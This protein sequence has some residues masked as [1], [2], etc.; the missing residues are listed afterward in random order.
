MAKALHGSTA[1]FDK[2]HEMA[3]DVVS[4]WDPDTNTFLYQ[5]GELG[6]WLWEFIGVSHLPLEGRLVEEFI[7]FNAHFEMLSTTCQRLF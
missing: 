3:A 7:P 4:R 6:I 5:Y 2:H 1:N